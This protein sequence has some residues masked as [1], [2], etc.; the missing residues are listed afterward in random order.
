MRK[1]RTMMDENSRRESQVAPRGH[2]TAQ[3]DS[4]TD[5][6]AKVR[7]R[8]RRV[9]EIERVHWKKESTQSLPAGRSNRHPARRKRP[10]PQVSLPAPEGQRNSPL[11]RSFLQINRKSEPAQ[12]Q[13]HIP[14]PWRTERHPPPRCK[15]VR[16][17]DPIA[18][19][20]R[21]GRECRHDE[22]FCG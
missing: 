7:A 2:E 14:Q 1:L 3:A 21:V 19:V 9:P 11:V 10:L 16:R 4:K 20:G 5:A 18:T 13:S 8:T 12:T 6:A 15:T 22:R 17:P